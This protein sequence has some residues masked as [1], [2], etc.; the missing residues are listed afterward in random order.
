MA[1]VLRLPRRL[2]ILLFTFV[3]SIAQWV[4]AKPLEGLRRSVRGAGN[5]SYQ[6]NRGLLFRLAGGQGNKR[7]YVLQATGNFPYGRLVAVSVGAPVPVP[8][9][10]SGIPQSSV[11]NRDT[12]LLHA[13]IG[14][15]SGPK[16]S[17]ITPPNL[18]HCSCSSCGGCG[19]CGSCSSCSGSCGT[20]CAG[21]CGTSC[22]TSCGNCTS[23]GDCSSCGNCISCGFGFGSS[24]FTNCLSCASCASCLSCSSCTCG[25]CASCG[26]CGSCASCVG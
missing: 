20:S 1:R 6:V 3:F 26:N 10:L 7:H 5:A 17:G 16:K 25:S 24:C 11:A 15:L 4:R 8:V 9:L 14:G 23:C 13:A 21:S 19:S 18:C 22:G 12:G 2:A